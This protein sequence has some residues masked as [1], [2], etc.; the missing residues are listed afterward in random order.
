V[1][2]IVGSV[3]RINQIFFMLNISTIKN[4]ENSELLRMLDDIKHHSPIIL[5]L[6]NRLNDA[7]INLVNVNMRVECP[8]CRAGL[9]V[10]FDEANSLF[11]INIDK[12]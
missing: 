6:C 9:I 4:L 8:V 12:P 2:Q 5:E 3:A 10:D 1:Q 7:E 11:N